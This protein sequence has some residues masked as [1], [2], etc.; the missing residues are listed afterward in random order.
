[1]QAQDAAKPAGGSGSQKNGRGRRKPTPPKMK[2]AMD[3]EK[4]KV[5]NRELAICVGATSMPNSIV[6]NQHFRSLVQTLDPQYNMPSRTRLGV[7]I[8][9]TVVHMKTNIQAVLQ[10]ARKINFCADIWTK[11]GFTSS[12]LGVTAHFFSPTD[13]HIRHA[14]LAVRHL[15]HPHTGLLYIYKPHACTC[16]FTSVGEC[17]CNLTMQIIQEWGITSEKVQFIVTDN[18]SNMVKAFKDIVL[19]ESDRSG[20]V[21]ME[22]DDEETEVEFGEESQEEEEG[23]EEEG[24]VEDET[25]EEEFDKK[26]KESN[27]ACEQLQL[28]RLACFSHMLQLVVSKFNKD[29]SAKALLSNTYKVV[30]SINKSSKM[31]EALVSTAGKKLVSSCKTRWTSAYLVVSRLLEVKDELKQVLLDHNATMLQPNEWEGLVLVE[32]LLAKFADYTNMAGGEKYSTLSSVVPCYVDLEAHLK[33]MKMKAKVASVSEVLLAELQKRFSKFLDVDDPDHVPIYLMAAVLDPRYR[34]LLSEDQ[35]ASVRAEILKCINGHSSEDTGGESEIQCE[36]QSSHDTF[37]LTQPPS[38]MSSADEGLP[39]AKR[40]RRSAKSQSESVRF[41]HVYEIMKKKAQVVKRKASTVAE[42]QLDSYLQ[43]TESVVYDMSL[44]PILFWTKSSYT[45]VAPF[46]LDLLSVPAS[47]A[48]V[49]RTFSVAG[50]ATAG[51]RNRL[52]KDNLENEIMLKKN[53]EYYVNYTPS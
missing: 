14:T 3:S 27:E 22:T 20:G 4:Q 21:H 24:Q 10:G 13:G 28:T 53:R 35:V 23:Q 49:E 41:T 34:L 45:A 26:E 17:I 8:D 12:Y 33:A 31:T 39:S 29:K 32:Q 18:G 16:Y 50:Y 47:S 1:M 37:E 15:P 30:N 36:S 7:L 43:S 52:A 6:T 46:A 51:R 40:R 48:A 42:L 38:G 44:D 2:Y 5:R 9:K 11:K 19:K 25:M